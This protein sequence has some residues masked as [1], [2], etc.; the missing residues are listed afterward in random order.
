M[1]NSKKLGLAWILVLALALAPVTLAAESDSSADNFA[2]L[3]WLQNWAESLASVFTPTESTPTPEVTNLED[4][5]IGNLIVPS[6]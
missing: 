6:G 3:Q 5:E 2:P 4:P 1:V